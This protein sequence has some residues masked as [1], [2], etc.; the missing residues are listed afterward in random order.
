MSA[1]KTERLMNLLIMLL[2]QKRYV[3]KERIR[4]ILY[5]DSSDEAFEKMFERDKEELRSL[6]VPIEVGTSDPLFDDDPGYR[7]S[8]AEFALPDIS[9]TA[10]EASVVALATKVWEH[11][12]LAEA[13]S[14]AVRKLSAAGVELDVAALDLVQPRLGADEPSFEPF[15]EAAQER[16]PVVFDYQRGSGPAQTRHVQP[17]GVVRSSGRW[18]VIGFD[19]DRDD[20][21]VFRLSRV[22]GEV[23][24]DGAPGSYD[25]PVGTDVRAIAARLAPER[26][27]LH[28]V[29]LLRPGTGHPLR[30]AAESVE[31]GVPGPDGTPWDRV[32]LTRATVDLAAEILSYGPDAFVVEPAALRDEVVARLEAVLA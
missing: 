25:I 18:Y 20:E 31:T 6:G 30:R 19:T 7:I 24:R 17:W 27:E 4:E 14:E 15:L 26:V 22:R 11:A 16:T 21:R 28:A 2:V 13:T 1:Q 32:V 23:R 5:A 8:P 10:D 3:T 9:L 12:R 29:L